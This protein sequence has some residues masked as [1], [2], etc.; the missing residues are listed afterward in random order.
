MRILRLRPPSVMSMA[1]GFLIAMPLCTMTYAAAT[2]AVWVVTDRLHPVHNVDGARV[3]EVDTPARVEAMLS[4]NLPASPRQAEIL[5][6]Q[7]LN[8]DNGKLARQLTTAYQ[9]MVDAWNLGVVTVPAVII[10]R[11]YV[12]YGDP[13]VAHAVSRIQAYREVHP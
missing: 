3:I 1:I 8:D 6:Q 9:G 5:V 7:R 12:V 4:A 13:D 11:H 10:D 2:N